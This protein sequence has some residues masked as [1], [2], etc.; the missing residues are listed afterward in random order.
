MAAL[1]VIYG[2]PFVF[3]SLIAFAACIVIPSWRRHAIQALVAPAA[4]GVCA[5]FGT[6]I[7][8]I[9]ASVMGIQIP[10]LLAIPIDLGVGILGAWVAIRVVGAAQRRTSA[11]TRENRIL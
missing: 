5:I 3:A 7:I 8:V 11:I 10:S 1:T 9:T 2:I 4:F 6:A